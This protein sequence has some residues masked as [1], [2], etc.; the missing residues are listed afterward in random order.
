MNYLARY[1]LIFT[2]LFASIV[3]CQ[4]DNYEDETSST[5]TNK[6]K[7][8]AGLP[9]Y[10]MENIAK[11]IN[12]CDAP[13][14]EFCV[15]VSIDYPKLNDNEFPTL[16][17]ELNEFVKYYAAD[18]I[19]TEKPIDAESASEF[20]TKSLEQKITELKAQNNKEAAVFKLDIDFEPIFYNSSISSFASH[21]S[22]FEGGAHSNSGAGYYIFNNKS[23]EVITD[24]FEKDMDLK[25]VLLK[26]LKDRAGQPD[27]D[28]SELGYLVT[29]LD[30]AITDNVGVTK[31]SLLLTYSPYEIAPYD[32]GFQ[33]FEFSKE[34]ITP[35]L[36]S[37][38]VNMWNKSTKK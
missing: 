34:E 33:N 7:K 31:D 2:V 16:K 10:E 9:F 11:S 38:F 20:L 15:D 35:Y 30:F 22:S 4:N 29:D 26:K 28:I 18:F 14:K 23:G 27:K 19:V 36:R 12:D 8:Q 3:A 24:I 37:S 13:T 5:K 32:M 25:Q 6:E 1:S 21:F 17:K